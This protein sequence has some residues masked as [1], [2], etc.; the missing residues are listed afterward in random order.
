MKPVVYRGGIV[1]FTIPASWREEYDPDGGG[2]FYEEGED[3]GTLRLN[4]LSFERKDAVPLDRAASEVFNGH[5]HQVL[6]SGFPMRHYMTKTEEE[7]TPLHLYRWEVLVPVP[8]TRWRLV[9]FS[10]TVLAARDGDSRVKEE[11]RMVDSA[12]RHAQ[13][14]DQQGVVPRKPWWRFWS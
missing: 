12:V 4:V 8:P 9:C 6:G 1:S 10:H 5:P 2:T 14:S 3:T 7:G 11:L 13:Y